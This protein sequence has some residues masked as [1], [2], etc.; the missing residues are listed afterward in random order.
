MSQ[1]DPHIRVMGQLDDYRFTSVLD[2]SRLSVQYTAH[3][4]VYEAKE[5]GWND[6]GVHRKSRGGKGV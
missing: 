2:D 5:L 1:L 6:V 3:A 4:V